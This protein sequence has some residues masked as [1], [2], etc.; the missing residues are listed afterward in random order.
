MH[1]IN[2]FSMLSWYALGLW[3]LDLFW[4]AGLAECPHAIGGLDQNRKVNRPHSFFRGTPWLLSNARITVPSTSSLHVTVLDIFHI[5]MDFLSHSYD[6]KLRYHECTE[7]PDHWGWVWI[8]IA[9]RL[10]WICLFAGSFKLPAFANLA[11]RN[12]LGACSIAHISQKCYVSLGKLDAFLSHLRAFGSLNTKKNFQIT[13]VEFGFLS[14]RGCR[15]YAFAGNLVPA[16][17]CC[18]ANLAV[19]N[20]LG[21][22]SIALIGQKSYA[23]DS[24]MDS[25]AIYGRLSRWIWD[26]KKSLVG[27]KPLVYSRECK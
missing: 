27:F 24:W 13:G 3:L 10:T 16:F 26:Y 7:L 21:A 11:V 20:N 1:S 17:C 5:F 2:V 12:N 25:S 19:H 22:C 4:E 9:S 18:N 6:W 14:H 15:G 23:L 8:F